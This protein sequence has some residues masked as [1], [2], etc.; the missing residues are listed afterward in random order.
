ME[1]I[2]GVIQQFETILNALREE[3][4]LI[5]E[6]IK[7][8]EEIQYNTQSEM[9]TEND[10]N[11]GNSQLEETRSRLVQME[12]NCCFIESQ[13]HSLLQKTNQQQSI[14]DN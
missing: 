5:K 1:E 12:S 13:Y 11:E 6:E 4:T 7:G 9:K 10:G 8:L 2:R 14:D 3:I